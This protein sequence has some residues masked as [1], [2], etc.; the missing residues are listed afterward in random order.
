MESTIFPTLQHMMSSVK[1]PSSVILFV[2]AVLTIVQT[3]HA[4][5]TRDCNQADR[6]VENDGVANLVLNKPTLQL[7]DFFNGAYPSSRAVDGN[8]NT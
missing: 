8:T 6:R 5:H 7:P 1:Y 3:G 2:L 4:I